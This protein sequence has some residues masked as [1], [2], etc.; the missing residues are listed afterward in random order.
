MTRRAMLC[1]VAGAGL[2]AAGAGGCGKR[3]GSP[4]AKW[5]DD[6]NW[7]RLE[8]GMTEDAVR[9][10]LG[11]PP[12]AEKSELFTEWFFTESRSYGVVTFTHGKVKSWSKPA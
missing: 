7:E 5:Q 11:D 10:L 1:L 2:A 6:A 9:S 12:K 4:A 3:G 8:T